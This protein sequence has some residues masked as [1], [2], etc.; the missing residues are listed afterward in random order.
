MFEIV[1]NRLHLEIFLV[2]VYYLDG[3]FQYNLLF[4][5][6]TNNLIYHLT[7]NIIYQ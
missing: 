4:Y 2:D 6:L 3:F 1:C 7:Y 5:Q